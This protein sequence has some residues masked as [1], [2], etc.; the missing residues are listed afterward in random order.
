MCGHLP[1]PFLPWSRHCPGGKDY[2]S[3]SEVA[4]WESRASFGHSKAAPH[5]WRRGGTFHFTIWKGATNTFSNSCMKWCPSDPKIVS[6]RL[7]NDAPSNLT[8][9]NPF[10]RQGLHASFFKRKPSFLT[11]LNFFRNWA[12]DFLKFFW[13]FTEIHWLKWLTLLLLIVYL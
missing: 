6:L 2:A 5:H 7:E 9:W 3:I 12:W 8:K 11:F 13:A 10:G 1:P 4:K